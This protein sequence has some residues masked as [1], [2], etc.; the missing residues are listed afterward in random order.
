MT[1]RHKTV[2]IAGVFLVVAGI[3]LLGFKDRI[4]DGPFPE[5]SSGIRYFET[6]A[7]ALDAYVRHLEK[8]DRIERVTCLTDGVFVFDS[9]NS[10]VTDLSEHRLAEYLALCRDSGVGMAW[11]TDGGYLLQMG[12]DSRS[13]RYFETAFVWRNGASGSPPECSLVTDLRDFGRCVV[14]LRDGWVIDYQWMPVDQENAILMY[15][16]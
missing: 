2:V 12:A 10:P 8:D 3:V 11:R 9:T 14:P 1:K 6:H 13:G 15:Q 16:K 7:T 4:V 5:L